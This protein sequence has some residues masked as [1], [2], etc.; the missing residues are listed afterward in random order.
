M[1]RNHGAICMGRDVAEA[2]VLM[3]YL[4]RVCALQL[5]VL[6]ASQAA[7]IHSPRLEVMRKAKEQ[8][9]DDFPAGK[10]EW[11]ALKAMILK[12]GNLT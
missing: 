7:P 5:K 12:E 4:E 9:R 8:M 1:M 2:F 3:Y 6:A 11:A 10:H